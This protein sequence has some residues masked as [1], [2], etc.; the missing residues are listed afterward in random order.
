MPCIM[1][2]RD[3][4][5]EVNISYVVLVRGLSS[6]TWRFGSWLS[7]SALLPALREIVMARDDISESTKAQKLVVDEE[8]DWDDAIRTHNH[9]VVVS[10]MA[11]NLPIDEA[12]DMA[13]RAWMRLIEQH[14]KGRLREVRLPGLAVTQARFLALNALK[15]K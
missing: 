11:L 3:T 13:H 9:R 4:L 8:I 15:S 7:H 10:L 14:K 5:A 2:V 1:Y 12:E 6:A